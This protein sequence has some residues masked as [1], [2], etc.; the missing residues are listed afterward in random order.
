MQKGYSECGMEDGRNYEEYVVLVMLCMHRTC[1]CHV[2]HCKCRVCC[3]ILTIGNINSPF[4]LT[5]LEIQM[6][7]MAGLG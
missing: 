5:D 3:K 6:V 2:H 7:I 4:L 1:Y